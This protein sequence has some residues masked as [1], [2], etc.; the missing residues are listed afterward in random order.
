MSAG[1]IPL[2]FILTSVVAYWLLGRVM[3]TNTAVSEP[4]VPTD[5]GLAS[6]RDRCD[7]SIHPRLPESFR[8]WLEQRLSIAGN[9]GGMHA[10]SYLVV[11][12]LAILLGLMLYFVVRSSLSVGLAPAIAWNLWLLMGAFP[13]IYLYRRGK[14]R[15][16]QIEKSLPDLLDRLDIA[17]NVG[18]PFSTGVEKVLNYLPAGPLHDEFDL[19]MSQ[20]RYGKSMDQAFQGIAHRVRIPEVTSFISA[21]VQAH[22]L[23]VDISQVIRTQAE[24]IRVQHRQHSEEEAAKAGTKLIF[25]LILVTLPMVF[26]LLLGPILVS[27]LIR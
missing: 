13:Y 6:L 23:G 26:I 12:I 22:R 20:V 19:A 21:V 4:F 7:R 15:Q 25:P 17:M 27:L 24:S 14:K 3:P 10:G 1:W 18:L 9:P 5:N 16:K 11:W 2:I 8:K